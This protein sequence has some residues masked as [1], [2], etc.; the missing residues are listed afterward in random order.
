MKIEYLVKHNNNI[1]GKYLPQD[2]NQ[3]NKDDRTKQS[4]PGLF[5]FF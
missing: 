5:C 4:H 1:Y 3:I 2:H